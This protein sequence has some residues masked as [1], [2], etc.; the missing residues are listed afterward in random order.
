MLIILIVLRRLAANIISR[1]DIIDI[2]STINRI[3]IVFS[4]ADKFD[5]LSNKLSMEHVKKTI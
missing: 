1:M 4:F 5:I 2:I 3:D